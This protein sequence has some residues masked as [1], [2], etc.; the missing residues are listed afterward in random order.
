[1]INAFVFFCLMNEKETEYRKK[2]ERHW[3]KNSVKVTEI[4]YQNSETK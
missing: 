2:N 4:I 3:L 1:M